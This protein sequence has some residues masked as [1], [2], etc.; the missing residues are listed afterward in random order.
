MSG[1]YLLRTV[2]YDLKSVRALVDLNLMGLDGEIPI[3]CVRV[4]SGRCCKSGDGM[5]STVFH[6]DQGM[7]AKCVLLVTHQENQLVTAG[8][9]GKFGT[10]NVRILDRTQLDNPVKQVDSPV[11]QGC[12]PGV[13]LR[14]WPGATRRKRVFKGEVGLYMQRKCRS[15][16]V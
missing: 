10:L 12:W 9:N 13:K 4:V 6:M 11:K 1:M 8:F 14:C 15:K 16:R 2:R 5:H 3:S 7:A